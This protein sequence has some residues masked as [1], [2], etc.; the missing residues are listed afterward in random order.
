MRWQIA[1][2]DKFKSVSDDDISK[3]QET[4]FFWANLKAFAHEKI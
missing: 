3:T 1:Q 2:Q 4:F